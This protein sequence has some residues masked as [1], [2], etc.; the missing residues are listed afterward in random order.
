LIP[1]EREKK[2]TIKGATRI[3]A[4]LTH[5]IDHMLGGQKKVKN[6]LHRKKKKKGERKEE[7]KA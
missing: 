7:K 6:K 3:L 4:N 1:H 5:Q 2:D